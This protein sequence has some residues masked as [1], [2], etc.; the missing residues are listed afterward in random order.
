MQYLVGIGTILVGAFIAWTGMQNIRTRTSEETGRRRTV[1]KVV[2]RSNTS[3][4]SAAVTQGRI[5][6]G[7]GIAMALFGL[8]FLFTG[9]MG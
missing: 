6:V 2:G 3:T 8:V 1:N 7:A 9:P 4:G 5:R